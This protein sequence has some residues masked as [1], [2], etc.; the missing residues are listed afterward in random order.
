MNELGLLYRYLPTELTPPDEMWG[1]LV[2]VLDEDNERKAFE[3]IDT[4]EIAPPA[5]AWENIALALDEFDHSKT[6]LSFADTV[7]NIEIAP[8]DFTWSE[9]ERSLNTTLPIKKIGGN[10]KTTK[11]VAIALAIAA[12]FIG[13]FFIITNQFNNASTTKNGSPIAIVNKKNIEIPQIHTPS[14]QNNQKSQQ[15]QTAT[16]NPNKAE[17][18]INNLPL[19]TAE[20]ST[21]SERVLNLKKYNQAPATDI[22][23]TNGKVAVK[24]GKLKDAFGNVIDKISDY[25]TNN[26]FIAVIGPNGNSVN[27]SAKLGNMIEFFQEDSIANQHEEYLDKVIRESNVWRQKFLDWRKKVDAADAKPSQMNFLDPIDLIHF[28]QKNK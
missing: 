21:D 26:G 23:T 3:D 5:A 27:V 2:K 4:L 15:T 9:I 12:C 25:T 7:S 14:K 18:A 11:I 13:A 28:L 6:V 17:V 10:S 8:P 24:T 1:R 19:T 22:N 20:S 16:S